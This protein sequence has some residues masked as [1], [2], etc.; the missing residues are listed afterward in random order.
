MHRICF[1]VAIAMLIAGSCSAVAQQGPYQ[2]TLNTPYRYTSVSN[3]EMLQDFGGQS[4]TMSTETRQY[5][6]FA[7]DAV[8]PEGNFHIRQT[9]DSIRVNVESPMGK[10][11]TG[12]E[13][14]GRAL[15]FTMRPDGKVVHR[16]SAQDLPAMAG[17]AMNS[18]SNAS[19]LVLMT[20]AD[21]TPG[22]SWVTTTIDTTGTG[23][24]P[25]VSEH[26]TTYTVKGARSLRGRDCVEI[27]FQGTSSMNGTMEQQGMKLSMQSEGGNSGTLFFDSKAGLLLESTD[28]TTMDMHISLGRG[29]GE[30]GTSSMTATTTTTYIPH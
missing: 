15:S 29:Q 4:F 12:Q 23:N 10:Q 18:Q 22:K 5:L 7:A 3:S 28:K 27:S 6:R 24:D 19:V 2:F 17:M 8:S 13:Y 9:L 26:R 30:V 1:P 11:A 21:F 16:D 25:L 20:G 14:D